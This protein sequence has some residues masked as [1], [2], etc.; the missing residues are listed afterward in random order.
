MSLAC[1][2]NGSLHI[3]WLYSSSELPFGL[4]KNGF[5]NVLFDFPSTQNG[6]S[7]SKLM[8]ARRQKSVFMMLREKK[9][10]EQCTQ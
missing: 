6:S 4:Q 3:Y 1:S 9:W 2:A 10:Q 8:A 5:A 7:I